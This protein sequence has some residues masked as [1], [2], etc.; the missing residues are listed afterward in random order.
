MI[1]DGDELGKPSCALYM[2]VMI[3][4]LSCVIYDGD[5]SGKLSCV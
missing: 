5:E 4:K 1:Y 3:G 2:M